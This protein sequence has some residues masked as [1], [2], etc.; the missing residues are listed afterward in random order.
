MDRL[1]YPSSGDER[2]GRTTDGSFAPDV[3]NPWR[4][5]LIVTE[6]R[7]TVAEIAPKPLGRG[8]FGR[9]DADIA[10][11]PK[12]AEIRRLGRLAIAVAGRPTDRK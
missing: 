4:S 10:R 11:P 7:F 3:E 9:P 1:V 6:G 5:A 12:G 2:C 8:R